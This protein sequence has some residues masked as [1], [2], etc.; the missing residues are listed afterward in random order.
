M[1][2]LSANSGHD[3]A[4]GS[5]GA[6]IPLA[7]MGGSLKHPAVKGLGKSRM[8]MAPGSWVAVA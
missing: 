3:V 5:A 1:L 8:I 7:V 6:Q 4:A 2:D